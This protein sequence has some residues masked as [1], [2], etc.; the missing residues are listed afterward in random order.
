MTETGE[1]EAQLKLRSTR[2]NIELTW[3]K[4]KVLHYQELRQREP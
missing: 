3:L 2:N 4:E 1:E